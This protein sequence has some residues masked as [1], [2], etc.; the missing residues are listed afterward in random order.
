MMKWIVLGIAI[1]IG[2]IFLKLWLLRSQRNELDKTLFDLVSNS[3]FLGFLIWKGSLLLLEL[4]LI[5][6]SP[7]SLLYFTGG[8][9]GLIL[10]IIGSFTYFFYKARKLNISF[11]I[12]LQ[13]AFI[14][15]FSTL[16]GYHLLLLFLI[17][18]NILFHLFVGLISLLLYILSLSKTVSSLKKGLLII[19]LAGLL[20]LGIFYS[21]GKTPKVKMENSASTMPTGEENI[22]IGVQEGNKASDFQMKT[23]EGEY[24]KLSDLKGKKVILNFWA[25][26][27]PPCKAE[28]PHMQD[29]YE[30]Q[31]KIV[32]ILAVNLTT[33]EKNIKNIEKFIKDN[34][35]T[36]PVLLDQEGET[37]DRYQAITIPTSYFIDSKGIIR[38]KIIGPMDKEMMTELINTID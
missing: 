20:A 30:E 16:C 37:G 35:I 21:S 5:V 24:I 27:C 13:S 38:K 33:S 34:H 29:F 6:K 4:K 36:F 19:S 17:K 10:G 2:F 3:V 9:K 32:E 1:L 7:L 18:E 25:T 23:I 26:W 31:N 11:F 28:M 14:F 22:K 12:T 15:S 8:D